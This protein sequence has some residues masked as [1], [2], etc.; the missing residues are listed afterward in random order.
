MHMNLTFDHIIFNSSSNSVKLIGCGSSSHFNSKNHHISNQELLEKD[1]RYISPEQT[2]R[3][4]RE[5][6]FRSDF[7]SLGIVFYIIHTAKY[8]FKD[9]DASKLL[10]LHIFQEPLS[11]CSINPNIPIPISMMISTLM[12]KYAEQRYQSA[13]G[14]IFDLDLILSEY[15]SNEDLTSVVLAQIDMPQILLVPIINGVQAR[16]NLCSSQ[17]EVELAI[18]PS[19]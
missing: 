17:E 16:L 4:N 10:D 2:G 3:V 7:Y 19:C 13:K 14:L 11:V 5:V 1:L 8:P 9:D 18:V 6:D 15:E 12:M